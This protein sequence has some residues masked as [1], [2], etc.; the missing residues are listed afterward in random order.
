MASKDEPDMILQPQELV[1]DWMQE[2]ARLTSEAMRATARVQLDNLETWITMMTGTA[3][4]TDPSKATA[5]QKAP[6]TKRKPG[7]PKTISVTP[8]ASEDGK[9]AT[10]A[11]APRA[12]RT[13]HKKAKAKPTSAHSK[14]KRK[15]RQ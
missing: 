8:Q 7:G 9:A 11:R 1:S 12:G 3:R 13:T 14:P 4:Q 5:E 6:A 10:K 2:A 15:P